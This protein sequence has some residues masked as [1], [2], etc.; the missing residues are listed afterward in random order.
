MLLLGSTSDFRRKDEF[1]SRPISGCVRPRPRG[2]RNPT[3]MS[4]PVPIERDFWPMGWEIPLKW[5]FQ[6]LS[7][8]I[9]DLWVEKSHWNEHSSPYRARFL[10]YGLRN[11]TEMSIPVPVE[12]DFWPMGWE[13]P[14]K[15]TPICSVKNLSN[16]AE[17]QPES[18]NW[19]S[20]TKSIW[21]LRH[22]D[23]KNELV[24]VLGF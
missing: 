21:N 3:E 5:A 22:L 16:E 20:A 7:S 19:K 6:S 24:N 23:F 12:R 8:E 1:E 2:L 10:T 15:W 11:P 18:Y 4:I 14:L 13:I 17:N 9:S